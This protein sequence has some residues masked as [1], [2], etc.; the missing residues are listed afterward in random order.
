M[1]KIVPIGHQY[2]LISP[3]N[4]FQYDVPNSLTFEELENLCNH[5]NDLEFN[6]F[7]EAQQASYDNGYEEGYSF[8]YE[9]GWNECCEEYDIIE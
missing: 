6:C 9:I 4:N 2:R 1:F 8:G 5:L 3:E 7:D